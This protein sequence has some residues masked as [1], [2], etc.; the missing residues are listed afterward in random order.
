M[1]HPVED[2]QDMTE[3]VKHRNIAF[4]HTSFLLTVVK[5][6][7]SEEADTYLASRFSCARVIRN[8]FV[9]Q[10][11]G[12]SYRQ[13]KTATPSI[14]D[15]ENSLAS[16]VNRDPSYSFLLS[17]ESEILEGTLHGAHYDWE[18]FRL[19]GM[20]RPAE[21]ALTDY[22]HFYI[23]DT[24][25]LAWSQ[26]G[27][28]LPDDVEGDGEGGSC[29]LRFEQP[30]LIRN[31]PSLVRII[32]DRDGTYWAAMLHDY[33]SEHVDEKAPPPRVALGMRL[34]E[35]RRQYYRLMRFMQ[36]GQEIDQRSYVRHRNAVYRMR[37]DA[38]FFM[39][40]GWYAEYRHHLQEKQAK[41][42]LA[43]A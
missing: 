14:D 38:F 40:R 12:L 30:T 34:S 18:M 19:R 32:R 37:L 42:K 35:A 22:K 39:Y 13:A 2:R 23:L 21:E 16:L 4:R 28:I 8:F 25:R 11:E 10:L 5:L 9:R 36:E 6:N 26:E 7:L 29:F 27:L 33:P 43:V 15:R 3:V 17:L 1:Q 24:R 20:S 31:R 41:H